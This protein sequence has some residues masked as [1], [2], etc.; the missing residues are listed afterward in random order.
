MDESKFQLFCHRSSDREVSWTEHLLLQ[1]DEMERFED[2]LELLHHRHLFLL[3]YSYETL[4]T[5]GESDFTLYFRPLL[6]GVP[7]LES[8]VGGRKEI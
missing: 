2:L 6:N 1:F 5:T 3:R 7:T 4:K 8:G